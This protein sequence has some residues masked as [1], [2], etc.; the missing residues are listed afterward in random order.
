MAKFYGKIGY[1]ETVED[2]NSP[3]VYVEQKT[4][5]NYIGDVTRNTRKYEPGK[6]LNDNLDV[7][8]TIS[9]VADAYAYDH[10]FA[11]RYIEWMGA[12]WKISSVEVQRPRLILS[13]G[14]V[15]NG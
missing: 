11:M 8:N 13:I 1:I 12:L 2:L 9:I 15:Y 5:R 14:G 7:N 10:F 4:E 6:N 3:G